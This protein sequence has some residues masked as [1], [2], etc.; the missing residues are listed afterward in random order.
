MD[1]RNAQAF[2]AV[3][4]ELHFGRAAQRLHIAQPPLSRLIRQL[5]ADLGAPL[6]ERNTR[7][8]ELTTH[9]E[10]LL[11]PAREL[12]MLSQRMRE[13]AKQSELGETGRIS[14][15]FG[16]AAA[17]QIVGELAR[18][19]RQN[20]PGI[21]LDLVNSQFWHTG[22]EKLIDGRLDLLI[23]RWDLLPAE[24]DSF[25]IGYDDELITLPDNHPLATRESIAP[26]ELAAEPWVVLQGG[27]SQL[28]NRINRL[29]QA[30]GFVPR[31]V[32]V[33]P[34]SSTVLL[35][36]AAG[37][38]ISLSLSSIRD[39]LPT[40]GVVFKPLNPGNDPVPV[41]MIWRRV[42]RSPVLNK[43]LNITKGLF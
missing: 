34:D 33:A 36:V 11:E 2:V 24:V 20:H 3:A 10:A 8:V 42:D 30:G 7:K 16:E 23:G 39:N 32:Q 29:A 4:E 41:R 6:F 26:A 9:G 17:N 19:V 38:G 28:P 37:I 31:I 35:L 14:L 25:V 40:R 22:I 5:E 43:V 21:T 27:N 18:R 12:I 15:G 1:V 13:I